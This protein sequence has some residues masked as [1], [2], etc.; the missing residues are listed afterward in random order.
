MLPEQRTEDWHAA[1]CGKVT[2]SRIVDVMAKGKSGEAATRATY[3]AELASE[4]LTGRQSESSFSSAA[5]R[6][7]VEAEPL[8]RSAYEAA[9]D[10]FIDQVMF[11]DH[12]TLPMAGASPDGLVGT[13]GLVEIKCPEPKQHIATLLGETPKREYLLQMQ[14]QMA[15]TGRAWCD[16][17]SYDPRTVD[18]LQLK[19]IRVMR[20][21][22]L[23]RD[24]EIEVMA[25]EAEVNALVMQL[26]RLKEAA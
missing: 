4:R 11:V 18:Y 24:I 3:K 5:I 16:F 12:P 21:D 25:F 9:R 1:R 8:A 6:W 15:C 17:V 10:C 22:Q 19:V 14:W 23:I 20:D 2:A 13:D 26:Q 7:G